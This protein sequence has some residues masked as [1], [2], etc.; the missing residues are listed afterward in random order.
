MK[1]IFKKKCRWCKI[2]KSDNE[3]W[4]ID[5]W[6]KYYGMYICDVCYDIKINSI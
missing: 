6:S 5:I 3:L 1:C 2:K 4:K